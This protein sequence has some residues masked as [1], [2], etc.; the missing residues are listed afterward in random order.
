MQDVLPTL[1]ELVKS[2]SGDAKG[3]IKEELFYQ[4]KTPVNN[5]TLMITG[6]EL[7]FLVERPTLDKETLYFYGK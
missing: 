7:L 2:Y 6:K 5:K 1:T 3:H 4:Y